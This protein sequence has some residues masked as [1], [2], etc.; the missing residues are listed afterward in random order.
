MATKLGEEDSMSGMDSG[1][2]VDSDPGCEPSLQGAVTLLAFLG[3][4]TGGNSLCFGTLLGLL[5]L[6]DT[7][8]NCHQED[9][10]HC[11]LICKDD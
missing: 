8:R 10:F 3:T 7:R 6:Q 4:L 9:L 5:S 11:G 2:K 1:P